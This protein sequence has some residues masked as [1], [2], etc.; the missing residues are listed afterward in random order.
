M[1]K[2][3]SL[4][5]CFLNSV[6]DKGC[7]NNSDWKHLIEKKEEK[8]VRGRSWVDQPIS[9]LAPGYS[10]PSSWISTESANILLILTVYGISHCMD[11]LAVSCTSKMAQVISDSP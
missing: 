11:V 7:Q 3:I 2:G 6:P 5:E 9:P 1:V 10:L 4:T 8:R